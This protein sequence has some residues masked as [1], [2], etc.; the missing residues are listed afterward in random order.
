MLSSTDISLNYLFFGEISAEFYWNCEMIIRVDRSARQITTLL[1]PAAA[2]TS[3]DSSL[4]HEFI[5]KLFN[6]KKSSNVQKT[7]DLFFFLTK[8]FSSKRTL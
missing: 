8:M 2:G 6:D 1:E 3:D 4:L 5:T 7:N